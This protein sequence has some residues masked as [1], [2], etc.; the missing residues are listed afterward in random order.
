MVG[1]VRTLCT[2]VISHKEYCPVLMHINHIKAIEKRVVISSTNIDSWCCLIATTHSYA[3]QRLANKYRDVTMSCS[4]IA[5]TKWLL[6]HIYINS[7][8]FAY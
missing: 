4:K 7:D 1:F 2:I 5:V 8:K 6:A 3:W